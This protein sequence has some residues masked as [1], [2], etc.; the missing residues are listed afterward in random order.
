MPRVVVA[1]AVPMIAALV[2]AA[3]CRGSV[4]SSG[5]SEPPSSPAVPGASPSTTTAPTTTPAPTTAAAAGPRPPVRTPR[6]DPG[7][8]LVGYYAGWEHDAL[9]PGAL[10][11]GVLTHVNYAFAIVT[12]DSR[13]VLADPAT[14]RPVIAALQAWK[15]RAGARTLL[16]VGGWEASRHFSEAASTDD[17][18]TRLAESCLALARGLGFDGIDLDWEY[19]S[20][21]KWPGRLADPRNH[22]ALLTTMRAQLQAGELLTVAM[23]ASPA[24]LQTFAVAGIAEV[25]DWINVMAYD[26][27]GPWDER[28]GHNAPLASAGGPFG[29]SP[30][31]AFY[32]QA[33]VP[34]A[35]LV[36]GVPFYGHAYAGV[37]DVDGPGAG[38][39]VTFTGTPRRAP[40]GSLTYRAV[41]PLVDTG[42]RQRHWDPVAQV[43]WLVD[44]AAREVISYD[45]PESMRA[46]VAF[47]R[48]EGLGGLMI[49]ELSGDT[50][51]FVLLRTLADALGRG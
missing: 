42:G 4:D 36:L 22:L 40:S 35:K 17:G 11:S 31:I 33:G 44:V 14:E 9:A 37:A 45:D 2:L 50:R 7:D 46:K 21:G 49:W 30:A 34:P 10:P 47:A 23:P 25:V 43:P 27:A 20:G 3:A 15:E 5:S 19:P 41:A 28:T 1:R 13:C 38:M 8:R 6:A 12:A 26:L 29:A 32:E 24:S 39:G 18:R 16:A 51:G 48:A